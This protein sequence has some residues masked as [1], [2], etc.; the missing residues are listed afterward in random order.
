MRA[1]T[2]H[3]RNNS[4]LLWPAPTKSPSAAPCKPPSRQYTRNETSLC[5]SA[6]HARALEYH[7]DDLNER[8][9]FEHRP[10]LQSNK[11]AMPSA[12]RRKPMLCRPVSDVTFAVRITKRAPA[13]RIRR[14]ACSVV[15]PPRNSAL[16]E[17]TN[18]SPLA[19]ET[20]IT[21]MLSRKQ[22]KNPRYSLCISIYICISRF[23]CSHKLSV[24]S[25]SNTIKHSLATSSESKDDYDQTLARYA[26]KRNM[27]VRSQPRLA[28]KRS[29]SSS[30]PCS[31]TRRN[32]ATDISKNVCFMKFIYENKLSKKCP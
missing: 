26:T 12:L 10:A 2:L 22:T 1:A 19:N 25:K 18:F 23:S 27:H 7:V 15:S 3:M 16:I 29:T 31:S 21:G 13:A 11:S 6:V 5:S 20:L 30:A 24:M 14:I 4:T 9:I 28:M 8:T 32:A 17:R